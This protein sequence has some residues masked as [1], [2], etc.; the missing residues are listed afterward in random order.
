MKKYLAPVGLMIAVLITS[1]Y[2]IIGPAPTAKSNVV[3]LEPEVLERHSAMA[4]AYAA[5]A[6]QGGK[7]DAS[8][9]PGSI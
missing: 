2:F 8:K 1:F 4:E 7:V 6:N 5:E 3:P 9:K